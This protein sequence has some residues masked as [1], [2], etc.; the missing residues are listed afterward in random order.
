MEQ[1]TFVVHSEQETRDVAKKF[2]ESI[3][4]GDIIWMVG[5]VGTGKTTFVRALMQEYGLQNQVSSPTFSLSNVY[6]APLFDFYHY[7]L[8][9]LQDIGLLRHEIEDVKFEPRAVLLIEWPDIS[10]SFIDA[11][12]IIE[13]NRMK[14]HES[15]RRILISDKSTILKVEKN[16]E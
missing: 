13:F 10:S 7:D 14:E 15:W 1:E 16:D 6:H 8:Y 4:P 2:S 12:K 5:D 9:R 11:T 3:V